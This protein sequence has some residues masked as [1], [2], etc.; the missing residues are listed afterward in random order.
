MS[1]EFKIFFQ[2]NFIFAPKLVQRGGILGVRLNVCP[3]FPSNSDGSLTLGGQSPF[4]ISAAIRPKIRPSSSSQT[5][6]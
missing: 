3:I 1:R 5:E 2:K 4:M 6:S